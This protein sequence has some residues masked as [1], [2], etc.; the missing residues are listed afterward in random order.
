MEQSISIIF[1]YRNKE[2][3]RVKNSLDSLNQQDS[4][5]FNVVFV[6]Y[7]SDDVYKEKIEALCKNYSFCKYI[8]IDT[9][10]KLWNRAEALNYGVLNCANEYIF[11][12][13]VDLVFKKSSVSVLLRNMEAGTAKFF[14]VG[15]LNEKDSKSIIVSNCEKLAFTKSEDFALGM[16]LLRKEEFEKVNGYNTFYSIWGIEDTDLKYRLEKAGIKA[17]FE[18]AV[19]MLHQ[20][21]APANSKDGSLPDGWVQYLKDY[22]DEVGKRGNEGKGLKE[23]IYPLNRPAKS[24]LLN[25]AVPIK[26]I[27]G[28]KLF[29]RHLLINDVCNE[30]EN[31]LHYVFDLNKS[32]IS[33]KSTASKLIHFFNRVFKVLNVPIHTVSDFSTQYLSKSEMMLEIYFVLK[34]FESKILDYWISE[35]R[36]EIRLIIIKGEK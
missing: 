23:L 10:G 2:I 35:E 11:T 21:H 1:C 12:A 33:A 14:S 18:H 9:Q 7:G 19:E 26:K 31:R 4:K 27:V 5:S 36:N 24:E 25:T 13:D 17:H 15:Y 29:V 32:E 28:R 8:F 6:D 20:Y 34:C 3:Q 16:V 30:T 22:F